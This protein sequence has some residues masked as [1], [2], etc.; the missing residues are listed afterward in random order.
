MSILERFQYN[1][2]VFLLTK[3]I[4]HHK[5][6]FS[7]YPTVTQCRELKIPSCLIFFSFFLYFLSLPLFFYPPLFL[8]C[9]L[10]LPLFILFIHF[11]IMSFKEIK[12]QVIVL[13][14]TLLV[15]FLGYSSQIAILW[16]FLGGATLHT[17]LILIPLNVFIILIYINYALTCLTDP[18]TVPAN[19]VSHSFLQKN[20]TTVA[21]T[22]IFFSLPL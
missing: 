3:S 19:W 22:T 16:T 2:T 14:V 11:R 10:T 13:F 6:G 8:Y 15:A 7:V 12:G 5:G 20:R 1:Y 4:I 9:P 18:G 17:A 21:N